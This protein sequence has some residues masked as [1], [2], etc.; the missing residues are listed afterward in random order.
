MK[1]KEH[2]YFHDGINRKKSP[3]LLGEAESVTLRGYSFEE[4]GVLEPR[5]TRTQQYMITPA[6]LTYKY[7]N[8][9][10]HRYET[11]VYSFQDHPCHGYENNATQWASD[12]LTISY[13][14][15]IYRMPC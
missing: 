11:N 6:T 8:Q 10:V 7:Y 14:N 5:P 2:F 15:H 4:D 9:G 12:A 13:F 1:E 3:L